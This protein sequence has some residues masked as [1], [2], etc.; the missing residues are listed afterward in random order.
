MK[1]PSGRP[2]KLRLCGSSD[3][4]VRGVWWATREA[5][6]KQGL[7]ELIEYARERGWS[8]R[9]TCALLALDPDRRTG[10]RRR[11]VHGGSSD[12]SARRDAVL[13]RHDEGG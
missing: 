4:S 11:A 9:R 12:L 5:L 10:V 3:M 7:L 6:V 13:G 2:L 1:S 8:R